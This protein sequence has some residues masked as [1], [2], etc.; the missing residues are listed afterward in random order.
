MSLRKKVRGFWISCQRELFSLMDEVLG[1]VTGRHKKL[2]MVLEMVSVECLLPRVPDHMPGRPLK[3]RAALARAFLAKMVFHIAT[4][5]ALL[6][7]VRSDPKLRRLCGWERLSDV[8]SEATFSRGSASLRKL[9]YRLG[10]TR[11]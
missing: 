8:P 9:R 5:R 3:Q 2:L 6:E 11:R 7:R 10:C 4:T 1:P